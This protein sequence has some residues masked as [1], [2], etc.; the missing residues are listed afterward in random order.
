M[1]TILVVDDRAIN[2][3]FLVTLLGYSQHHIIEASQGEEA[4]QKAQVE[5]P[6][7]IITDILMPVMGGYELALKLR[8][9]PDYN[10]IPVIFYTAT[11]RLED[12]A[13]I[14]MKCGVKYILS[15]PSDPQHILDTVKKA[16]RESKSE[17]SIE[18]SEEINELFHI[19]EQLSEYSSDIESIK[20]II[21]SLMTHSEQI[22]KEREK[23]MNI[24]SRFSL[25]LNQLT[26]ISS[27]LFTLI[28][29]HLELVL[30]DEP[31]SLFHLFCKGARKIM[32]SKYCVV[33]LINDKNTALSD[34]FVVGDEVSIIPV[35]HFPSIKTG[36]IHDVLQSES[37]IVI[38]IMPA[39]QE[40][41]LSMHPIQKCF[42]GTRIFTAKK[43]YGFLY[44]TD[45]PHEKIFNL[46]DVEI[47]AAL[48]SQ[49]AVVYENIVLW[50]KLKK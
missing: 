42:V 19:D 31:T 32:E 14:A 21:D 34:Y 5:H 2:R 39:Q 28:E 38:N 48:A 4:L 3:K 13:L 23:L 35:D 25:S 18:P 1:A 49:I 6:D 33:G 27:R 16:L 30:Q 15:K 17:I 22:V 37:P 41:T 47:A 44:F 36:L 11:Y 50:Q 7:L 10:K 8:E 26:K 20:P 43:L 45:K 12:A 9:N 40:K 46:I 29:L 24:T